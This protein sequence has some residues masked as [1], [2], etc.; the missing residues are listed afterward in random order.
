MAGGWQQTDP[1]RIPTKVI[2]P[3]IQEYLNAYQMDEETSTVGPVQVLADRAGLHSDS[4]RNYLGYR[5]Q[6]MDFDMA[7]R[8]ICAIG[9]PMLWR[10]EL[11]EWYERVDLSDPPKPPPPKYG[12]IRC[13]RPGCTQMFEPK[14][15]WAKYCSK[16]CKASV[17]G[18]R[19]RRKK[20]V[21]TRYGTRWGTC[22]RGHD[23]SEENVY[24]RRNGSITCRVCRKEDAAEK[25][26]DEAHRIACRDRERRRRAEKRDEINARRRELTAQRRVA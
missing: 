6:T 20:G 19:R 2:V 1:R 26:K 21:P 4:L 7:D 25:M 12:L 13:F 18:N 24:V 17:Q 5:K 10:S 3:F 22:P 8:L 9:R 23:R 11:L 14:M 16:A 15:P